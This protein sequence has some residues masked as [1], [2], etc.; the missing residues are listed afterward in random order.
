[1]IS[2]GDCGVKWWEFVEM[3]TWKE[4]W[5][6]SN[7]NYKINQMIKKFNVH[8]NCLSV[9]LKNPECSKKY[10]KTVIPLRSLVLPYM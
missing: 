2:I 8:I 10:S 7:W 4:S 9:L 5:L 1:M 3:E 6:G